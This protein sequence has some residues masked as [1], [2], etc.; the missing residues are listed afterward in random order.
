MFMTWGITSAQETLE[1]PPANVS[2]DVARQQWKKKHQA[3]KERRAA[4]KAHLK[5]QS[6]EVRKRMKKDAKKSENFNNMHY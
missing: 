3:E 6:K 4:L 1:P 5:Q 2:K